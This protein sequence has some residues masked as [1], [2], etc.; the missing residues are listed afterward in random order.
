[1]KNKIKELILENIQYN[2]EDLIK[3]AIEFLSKLNAKYPENSLS[4]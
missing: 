2:L 3:K 1:M 4:I